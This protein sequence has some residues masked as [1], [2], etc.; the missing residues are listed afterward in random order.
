MNLR[1]LRRITAM[2][3]SCSIAASASGQAPSLLE[4]QDGISIRT[5]RLESTF[6]SR[7]REVD[8][9]LFNTT[10]I[11][12]SL[13]PGPGNLT[14]YAGGE[15]IGQQ[16]GKW[17]LTE[18]A[19]SLPPIP[20]LS[21]RILPPLIPGVDESLLRVQVAMLDEQT[22]KPEAAEQVPDVPELQTG[23]I[24]GHSIPQT[25][26]RVNSRIYLKQ[27]LAQSGW[28]YINPAT[29]R[30]QPPPEPNDGV[31]PPAPAPEPVD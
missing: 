19:T 8:D 7:K 25:Y 4:M 2:A 28:R 12:I 18:S 24:T 14:W 1:G 9:V 22:A 17:V 23:V 30:Q 29:L 20:N 16:N 27:D 15:L 26:V 10:S 31:P 11:N 13:F 5:A 3:V 6:Q 21:N